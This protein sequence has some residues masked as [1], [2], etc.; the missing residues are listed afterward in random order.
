MEVFAYRREEDS[1]N[2]LICGHGPGEHDFKV[3]DII[4]NHHVIINNRFDCLLTILS[5][6]YILLSIGPR[7]IIEMTSFD[8]FTLF[9]L[10]YLYKQSLL[11]QIVIK[12]RSS[13]ETS[14]IIL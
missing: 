4:I 2:S 5:Q 6:S 13:G 10:D 7:N 9:N 3:Y 1:F 11:R 12:G 14:K 8:C